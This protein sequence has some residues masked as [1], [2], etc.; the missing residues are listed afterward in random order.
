MT[1]K[2]RTTPRWGRDR[3]ARWDSHAENGFRI[4][5]YPARPE[6]KDAAPESREAG[7]SGLPGA[8]QRNMFL[9]YVTVPADPPTCTLEVATDGWYRN[10]VTL[11]KRQARFLRDML[12]DW[13]PPET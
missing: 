1:T 11:D 10:V 6:P 8:A 5:S 4:R 13:F 9:K 2:G 3:S 12:N 7:I